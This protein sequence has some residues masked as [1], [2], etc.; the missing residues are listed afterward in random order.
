MRIRLKVGKQKE[1]ILLAKSTLTWKVL[2]KKLG[3][4]EL[5]LSNELR[6]EKRL[7][8]KEIYEILCNITNTNFDSFVVEILDD[9][10]GRSRGGINSPKTMKNF[11]EPKKDENLAEVFG[12]ILGDG[13]LSERIIGNKIRVYCVRI[14]GNSKS[15]RDYIFDYIPKIFKKV[16]N[17]KGSLM[18]SKKSNCGY[19]TLYGKKLVQF[20][21]LNGLTPGN[22]IKNSQGIPKWIKSNN[23]FLKKCLRGL[24]DTDGSITR[25][26]KFNKNLRI[27]FTNHNKILLND[28]RKAFLSLGFSPSK[29]INNK[30]FFISKQ[31][32]II[33]Y[34]NDIGF[35]NSKNL[36][37]Y[38]EF[39]YSRDLDNNALI[40]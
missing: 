21:K 16:F 6:N 14:A 34:Y 27:D 3:I 7:I 22:K 11:L 19:F 35:G 25:I 33:K 13:H 40:V 12:I 28:T 8:S 23:S 31:K 37:R 18:N 38:K 9:N 2:A 15:D 36:K 26:S 5:Y 17:E 24:I 30:H 32:E 29:I 1:L 10:W 20:F 39:I 4:C